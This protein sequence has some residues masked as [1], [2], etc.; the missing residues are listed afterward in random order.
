MS[1][2]Q[3]NLAL[4]VEGLTPTK[5]LILILLGN[6]CD[7]K[8]SCYP[9][10]RHI[11]NIVGLKDTKGVQRTIKEFQNLGYLTIEHRKDKKG[12][13]TSNR[14]HLTLQGVSAPIGRG[15]STHTLSVSAPPNTKEDTKPTQRNIK[16]SEIK[17]LALKI[18]T[19]YQNNFPTHKNK[20]ISTAHVKLVNSLIDNPPEF[21]EEPNQLVKQEVKNIDWWH[22]YFEFC[23]SSDQLTKGWEFEDRKKIP[24]LEFFLRKR[25]ILKVLNGDYH[26]E[27]NGATR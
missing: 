22:G 26:Q 21:E 14:Y 6:Y 1:I 13:K 20:K 10:Y 24:D 16:E 23:S 25:S 9:S 3:L 8:G 27:N 19:I 7:E 15:N 18:K 17:E 11:A 12:A 5:K 2:E 4:R